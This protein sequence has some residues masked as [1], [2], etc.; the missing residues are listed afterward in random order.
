MP[1]RKQEQAKAGPGDHSLMPRP[2]LPALDAGGAKRLSAVDRSAGT[3]FQQTG[4]SPRLLSVEQAAAY[5][6]VS[7]RT[8]DEHIRP[9]LKTVGFTSRVLIDRVRL[10]E[11]LDRISSPLAHAPEGGDALA[12]RLR[13]RSLGEASLK[14]RSTENSREG[15]ERRPGHPSQT[16]GRD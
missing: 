4:I 6:G 10:D 5:C 3:L 11:E 8:F 7:R 1:R 14:P 15:A 2:V 12:A 9:R 13:A 16:D